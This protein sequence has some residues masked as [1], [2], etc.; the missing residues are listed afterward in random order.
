M[1]W[2]DQFA[3]RPNADHCATGLASGYTPSRRTT[4][5]C[6]K[7]AQRPNGAK[8]TQHTEIWLPIPRQ[9]AVDMW[10]ASHVAAV[11]YGAFIRDSLCGGGGGG[12]MENSRREVAI[13]TA[14]VSVA[15]ILLAAFMLARHASGQ[16]INATPPDSPVPGSA[17]PTPQV[18]GTEFSQSDSSAPLPVTILLP[19]QTSTV[20]A[21]VTLP[22]S[23]VS[24]SG[25][26]STHTQLSIHTQL[27]T[28]TA[29]V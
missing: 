18:L 15:G 28:S 13:A 2:I 10:R 14:G 3:E 25:P 20:T 23:T 4:E 27:Q 26:A 5:S 21:Q 16:P 12:S 19:G 7:C 22:G 1:E 9:V 6:G 17:T 29:F 24:V 11:W 8:S